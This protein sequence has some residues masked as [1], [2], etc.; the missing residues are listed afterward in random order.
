MSAIALA[1]DD[2]VLAAGTVA[3][4]SKLHKIDGK[5]CPEG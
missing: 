5:P 1:I 4:L 3:A 2:S